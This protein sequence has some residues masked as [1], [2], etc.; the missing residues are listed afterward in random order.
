MTTKK[1]GIQ[2]QGHDSTS[3]KNEE[4]LNPNSRGAVKSNSSVSASL[5]D[6][7]VSI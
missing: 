2:L 7:N 1:G 5:M 3:R 6:Y 4:G